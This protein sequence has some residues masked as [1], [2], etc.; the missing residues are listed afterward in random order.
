MSVLSANNQQNG[1][2]CRAP[3][4][5]A[6]NIFSNCSSGT[7]QTRRR[8]HGNAGN[9][10][11][12]QDRAG[13]NSFE[14]CVSMF[15]AGSAY[16]VE[17]CEDNSFLRCRAESCPGDA[18]NISADDTL[19]VEISAIDVAGDAVSIHEGSRN[20]VN[21]HELHNIFGQFINLAPGANGD[22]LSLTGA[23]LGTAGG[24]QVRVGGTIPGNVSGI[25]T[26][27]GLWRNPTSP[28]GEEHRHADF[29]FNVTKGN[30][31][32]AFSV[33]TPSQHGF[34]PG[35]SVVLVITTPTGTAEESDPINAVVDNNPDLQSS[36]TVLS[37]SLR[38]GQ[39]MHLS[40]VM[41]NHGL[42]RATNPVATFSSSLPI[43]ELSVLGATVTHLGLGRYQITMPTL[44]P[45]EK[46]TG[47]V[48]VVGAGTGATTIALHSDSSG[49]TD[50]NPSNNTATLT[51]SVVSGANPSPVATQANQINAGSNLDPVSMLTGEIFEYL[52]SDLSLGGPLPLG[53][54]RYYASFLKR[55]GVPGSLGDNWRHNHEWSLTNRTTTVEVSTDLGRFIRFTNL[56][57]DYQ[58]IGRMEI[59]FQ[60]RNNNGNFVL[61]DP[62]SRRLYTFNS[63]GQLNQ[64]A[65]GRGNTHTLT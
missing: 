64:V 41:Q 59:P 61:G 13:N 52:P 23:T 33:V 20:N 22:A 45:G 3:T 21:F 11:A 26:I 53:F 36:I 25:S 46:I 62:R 40:L 38:L 32:Q 5:V 14:D 17:G 39:P 54:R 42:G 48:T 49:Q 8:N 18:W 1:F 51:N 50:A 60:L 65:D 63:A 57:G 7:D 37:G 44:A 34:Q 15:N 27:Q 24:S 28:S 47:V 9:G 35:N 19:L 43:T 30:S 55:V 6:N 16:L 56:A 2:L 4:A 10:F 12:C 58:L 31:P 29:E